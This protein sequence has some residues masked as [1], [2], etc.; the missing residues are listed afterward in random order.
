MSN[1]AMIIDDNNVVGAGLVPAHDVVLSDDGSIVGASD[2]DVVPV[3]TR[4]TTR[5]APTLGHVIGTYESLVPIQPFNLLFPFPFNYSTNQLFNCLS[6]PGPSLFF[7][8]P[9]TTYYLPFTWGSPGGQAHRS[10]R[11]QYD[12][13]ALPANGNQHDAWRLSD[14][15]FAIAPRFLRA[16]TVSHCAASNRFS[17]IS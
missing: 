17:S 15:V 4:A 16:R 8:P 6:L 3:N 11:S 14:R 12:P 13:R 2:H 7:H 5:V 10:A 1:D 9:P